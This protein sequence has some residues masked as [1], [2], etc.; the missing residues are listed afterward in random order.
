[1]VKLLDFGIAKLIHP[2]PG[3]EGLTMAGQRLG[4]SQA[5]APEQFRGGS[6]GPSTD[7]YALGVLLYQMLTG[8]YPYQSEDR[9]EVERMHLEA[10]PPR[11]SAEAPVPPAVDAVVLR[12][13]EKEAERRFPDV[14]SFRA[15][16]QEA[17]FPSSGERVST[18]GRSVRAF[19]LHAEVVL[20]EGAED[21]AAYAAVAE[22]L[23]ALEQDL[24]AAGFVLAVQ[25]GMALLGVRPLEEPPRL[26]PHALLVTA[27]ELHERA[28]ARAAGSRVSVHTCVHVGQV[29]AR[30]GPDGIDI[31]GGP[32][33]DIAGW[34]V[35]DASG[36][37]VTPS[38][39]R[40]CA[41][42]LAS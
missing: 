6:I 15:A 22:V 14:A 33:A 3:Q 30:R 16:L 26:E 19:A 23:D 32:L 39:A 12:C 4:T 5:M 36:F 40:A 31:T 34:V 7:I 42:S 11:P 1:M 27:R 10:P 35:R 38:A 28:R 8:H 9:L 18:T 21:D 20:E 17:V 2:E 29:D 25:T 24:R 13:L 37:G 41:L